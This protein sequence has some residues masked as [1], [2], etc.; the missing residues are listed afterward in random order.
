MI[1]AAFD[2]DVLAGNN[3]EPVEIEGYRTVVVRVGDR[4][5]PRQRTLDEV[6][7]EIVAALRAERA[8]DETRAVGV[9]LLG[10]LRGGEGREAVAGDLAWSEERTVGRDEAD[11][12]RAVRGVLFSMPRPGA[13]AVT[14]DG[15]ALPNGDF[16][17]LALD[18]VIENEVEAEA[19]GES[20]L[21]LSQQSGLDAHD[22]F[23]T[24]LRERAEVRVFEDRI[25][26]EDDAYGR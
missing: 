16:V 2:D 10:R 23:V 8:T 13:G 22:S 17:I 1:A 7:P 6:R 12:E 18:R 26:S 20:R 21:R 25:A 9:N 24:A 11:L 15:A 3:S 4:R 5:E 19:L 14:F